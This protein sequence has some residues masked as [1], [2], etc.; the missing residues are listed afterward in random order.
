MVELLIW[1][2]T[3]AAVAMM[4]YP[5]VRQMLIRMQATPPPPF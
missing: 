4:F 5:L 3:G 1:L 2:A